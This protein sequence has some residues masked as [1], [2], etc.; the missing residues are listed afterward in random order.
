MGMASIVLYGVLL[1]PTPEQV[2][3]AMVMWAILAIP[4][5]LYSL[6]YAT[7][8]M[9]PLVLLTILLLLGLF[10]SARLGASDPA[11]IARDSLSVG[12]WIFG[13]PFIYF[14]I[15]ASGAPSDI[16]KWT[17]SIRMLLAITGLVLS[18]RYVI[19]IESGRELLFE[20]N[21]RV[22]L[23]YL[24]SEPLVA[25]AFA[26]FGFRLFQSDS[27]PLFALNLLGWALS[28]VG[29]IAVT[30]RGPLVIGFVLMF[31][32]LAAKIVQ[33]GRAIVR[34]TV[35]IFISSVL[36]STFFG[37]YVLAIIE[38]VLTKSKVVGVN[39][40]IE[41]FTSVFAT[42]QGVISI[43][44]GNGFGS[45]VFAVGAGGDVA[46]THNLFSYVFFKVGV[47]GVVILLAVAL[48]LLTRLI[49]RS[50]RFLILLPELLTLL[51]ISLFQGA[52]KHY[53]FSLLLGVVLAI[54]AMPR[55][56]LIYPVS[57]TLPYSSSIPA[58]FKIGIASFKQ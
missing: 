6:R 23:K 7:E 58:R 5:Y 44:I 3:W 55:L 46:F 29:L 13:G 54:A 48:W 51:Y 38:K 34:T 21:L 52:Y 4:P 37:K 32:G 22:N 27:L 39:S 16:E 8:L 17:S 25:F 10:S 36:V 45:K 19:E 20:K 43:L 9:V 50:G 47:V 30:Y 26:F 49:Q 53:G 41:E 2:S 35:A 1:E 40:K 11:Q 42:D 12:F 15:K 18:V 24:S 31:L 28:S 57:S 56:L 33:S 14:L